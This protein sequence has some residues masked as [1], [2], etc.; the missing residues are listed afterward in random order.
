[1]GSSRR[2]RCR[3]KPAALQPAD[4]G[5]EAMDAVTTVP[6]PTNVPPLGFGPGSVERARLEIRLKEMAG[7]HA[8][9]T[10]A[11]GTRR[12]MGGGDAIEVVAPHRRHTV[13]GTTREAT[14]GDVAVAVDTALAAAPAWAAL[15][16]DDR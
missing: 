15:S 8:E 3:R 5:V 4:A 10:M 14:P 2:R 16:F 6:S 11:Q 9:L 7:E 1:M 13:L 12:P